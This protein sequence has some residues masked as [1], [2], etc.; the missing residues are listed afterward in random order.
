MATHLAAAVVERAMERHP[1]DRYAS[2][3]E[4]HAD[5]VALAEARTPQA[6]SAQGGTI[7]R[8]WM[9]M[10]YISSGQPFEYRSQRTFLGLPLVHVITGFR[11]PRQKRRAA[12]GWIAVGDIAYGGLAFGGFAAGGLAFGGIAAGLISWGGIAGALLVSCGGV[13]LGGLLAFGGL[14]AGYVTFGGVA[15][16]YLAVGGI[17][18]GVYAT[19]GDPR[20][21]HVITDEDSQEAQ[22]LFW[23]DAWSSVL[24]NLGIDG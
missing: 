16:G 20:G 13:S 7:G 1:E 22:E 10:R 12:K 3:R 2:A 9:R 8:S 11:Y 19:G 23:G 21:R 4:L 6:R 14:A 18:R 5:L 24:G 15:L 17:A